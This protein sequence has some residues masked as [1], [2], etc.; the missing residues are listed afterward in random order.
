MMTN[1]INDGNL[2]NNH[3]IHLFLPVTFATNIKQIAGIANII[4]KID[5]FSI[6]FFYKNNT[7]ILTNQI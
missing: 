5:N 1:E 4:A 3:T 2:I 7:L 6:I